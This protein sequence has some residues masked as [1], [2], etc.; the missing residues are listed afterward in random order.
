VTDDADEGGYVVAVKPSAR[1]TNGT[2]GRLVYERGP[3]ERFD[4]RAFAE[5]WAR[6]LSRGGGRVWIRDANPND[7][8]AVDGYLVSSNRHGVETRSSD[9]PLATFVG[10][11]SD[12]PHGF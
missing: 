8:A 1:R 5:E 2:V 9:G 7:D 11:E 6:A 3:R 10:S 12:R 4:S